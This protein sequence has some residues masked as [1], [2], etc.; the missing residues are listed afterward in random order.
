[1]YIF[2]TMY[3]TYNLYHP[4]FN[5]STTSGKVSLLTS[6]TLTHIQRLQIFVFAYILFYN[7]FEFITNIYMY[8]TCVYIYIYICICEAI[9]ILRTVYLISNPCQVLGQVKLGLVRLVLTRLGQPWLGQIRYFA[10]RILEV[11][12]SAESVQT[13]C[14]S[15]HFSCI[16]NGEHIPA[17]RSE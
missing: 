1:M 6:N 3:S 13:S 15:P 10:T 17:G 4:K 2:I 5:S 16:V 11:L 8:K 14:R 12:N 9:C 7:Y